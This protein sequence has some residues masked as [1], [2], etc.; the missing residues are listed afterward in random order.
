[1]L[2]DADGVLQV[3][4]GFGELWT[5]LDD[6]VRD[7]VLTDTFGSDMADVLTGAVDMSA[8]IDEVLRRHGLGEH[9]DAIRRT[10]EQFPPVAEAHAVVKAV[11]RNG[12]VCVLATNQDSLREQNM[13]PVYAPLLDRL[14]FSSALGVAKPAAAFFEAISTD[15]GVPLAE[16]LLIDDSQ[17]NVDGA[18]AA[19]LAAERWHHQDGVATLEQLLARHGVPTDRRGAQAAGTSRRW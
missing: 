17:A 15:L 16:L 19:G 6:D 12:V 10:W 5:F 4:P 14:Y 9:R 8:R 1:V 3:L 7:E 2:W 11:R 18:R 13:R